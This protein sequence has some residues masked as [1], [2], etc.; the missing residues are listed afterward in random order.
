MKHINFVNNQALRPILDANGSS[1]PAV[2]NEWIDNND[3]N[4]VTNLG[5]KIVFNVT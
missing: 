3:N 2:M 1:P 4:I 5:Q